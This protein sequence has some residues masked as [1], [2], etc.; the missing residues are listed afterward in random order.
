MTDEGWTDECEELLR[1]WSEKA[2]CYRWLSS[3]CEKKYRRYY[4]SLSIP[5]IILSTLTGV[6]NAGMSS[7]V[8][9]GGQKNATA[10]IAG[11][12]IFCG[13]LG[14]LSNFLKLSETMESHRI[15][16]ISWSKLGRQIQIELALDRKRRQNAHD[17]LK[18][19]R[20]EYDR[21]IESSPSIDDDIIRSFK[22]TFKNYKELDISVPNI[23]NGLDRVSI[24]RAPPRASRS[25][26]REPTSSTSEE[27]P[28]MVDVESPDS[29]SIHAQDEHPQNP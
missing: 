17:F 2:N 9:E 26:V 13:I 21:L 12:N 28:V 19:S 15:Q 8:S 22:S 16:G 5:V 6:A 24:F 25:D 3:K 1:E 14:T 18:I 7:Y 29:P 23:C 10:V 4:Y 11:T 27:E 20:A